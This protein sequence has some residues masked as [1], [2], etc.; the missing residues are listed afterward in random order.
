[1]Q[2]KK[3]VAKRIGILGYGLDELLYGVGMKSRISS[4]CAF[5][6]ILTLGIF[7]SSR[8]L[9]AELSAEMNS[10][11]SAQQQVSQTSLY[12]FNISG[13]TLFSSNQD[14]T[15]NG[16][17]IASL[18]RLMHKRVAID[19]GA[20][21]FR[22][23]DFPRGNRVA[24]VNAER[25]QTYYLVV[26]YNPA[27]SWAFPIFGDSMLIKMVGA[28]EAEPLLKETKAIEGD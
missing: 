10:A 17:L 24:T 11:N 2:R 3:T 6:A 15:D 12:I 13:A 4:W 22:F 25:G 27:K 16:K 20:H 1:M 9:S 8:A 18:P 26:G 28:S 19:A 5:A 14:I 21:E 23:K 7:I